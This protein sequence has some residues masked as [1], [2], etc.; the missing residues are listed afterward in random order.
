[1]AKERN[2]QVGTATDDSRLAPTRRDVVRKGA[3]LA[4]VVPV[5]STF[6]ASEAFAA[7]SNHSCYPLNHACPGQEP[8]CD[9]LTC[10]TGGSDEC[11]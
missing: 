2:E 6:F 3:K 4:F 9:G 1:M 10:D 8:C 7:G 11:R 5:L